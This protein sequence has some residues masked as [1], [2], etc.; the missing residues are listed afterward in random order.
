MFWKVVGR[1]KTHDYRLQTTDYSQ[2]T[3]DGSRSA[4]D[5]NAEELSVLRHLYRFP[6]VLQEAAENFSPNLLCNFLYELAQKYNNLYN[7]H[8]IIGNEFRLA[9]TKATGDI[10]KKGLNLLGI[11]APKKM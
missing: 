6:E 2:N 9:L 11:E 8:R 10:L 4:V 7:T 3:V 1:R 5:V